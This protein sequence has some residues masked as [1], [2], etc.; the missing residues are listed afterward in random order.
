MAWLRPFWLAIQLLTTLPV[1]ATPL[2]DGCDQGRSVLFYPLVGYLLAIMLAL[3][4]WL[5]SSLPAHLAAALLLVGWIVLTGALHLDGLADTI[6][7][8]AASHRQPSRAL[9]VMRD[10]LCGPVAV[11]GLVAHLLLKWSALSLLLG[12][13]NWWQAAAVAAAARIALPVLFLTT[14]YIRTDGIA[15]DIA[16]HLPRDRIWP[17][18]IVSTLP[19]VPLWGALSLPL[20]VLAAIIFL[21]LRYRLVSW[22]GGTT[23]DSAGALVELLE[24]VLLVVLAIILYQG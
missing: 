21:L 8:L 20:I 14:P 2:V 12:G 19:L 13:G 23:G 4:G 6:D 17:V 1:P 9:E 16:A 18:V 11:V 7:A 24:T 5:L 3:A 10:P 22:L 15:T